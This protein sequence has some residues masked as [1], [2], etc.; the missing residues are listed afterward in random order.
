MKKQ[1]GGNQ[2]CDLLMNLAIEE[3]EDFQ[4]ILY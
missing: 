2:A 3:K 1:N 4:G